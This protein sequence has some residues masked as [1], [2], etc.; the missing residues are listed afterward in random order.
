M[1]SS[2]VSLT[3]EE[4]FSLP[5]DDRPYE[6]IDGRAVPKMSPKFFHSRIQK[7]ILLLLD[8]WSENKGRVE[9]EWAVVLKRRDRDWVPVPDLIYISFDRLSANWMEDEACPVAP[10]LVIEI[11][12]PGQTFGELTEKATDY[13][14]AGVD[15]VW[16]VDTKAKTIAIF[17]PNTFPRTF[18]G[19][20][21]IADELLPGLEF[22]P[23]D[24]FQ[25]SGIS[26]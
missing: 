14:T 16:I 4:F 11:V 25:R 23:Q 26:K 6:L 13:L 12:S 10:E 17:Y 1:V 8:R 20:T 3:L 18:R 24:I 2:I 22:S 21:A 19:D 15:R 5:E 9:P 7:T